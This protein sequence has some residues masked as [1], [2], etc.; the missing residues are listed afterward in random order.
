MKPSL[1][2]GYGATG[3]D[4]EKYLISESKKYVIYDDNKNI[5]NELNFQL[6]DITNLEMIYV[7]PGIRKDHKILNIAEESNIKVTTDI[8]YFNDIS[9]VKIVGVT[10]TNGKTTFVSLLNKILNKYGYKSNVAG[11]IGISPLN[12]IKTLL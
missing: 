6:E 4:I 5:P 8:E 10:G 1:I 11:N 2:L 12:L 3:K 7:S 9:N